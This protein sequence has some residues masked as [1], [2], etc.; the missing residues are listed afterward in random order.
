MRVVMSRANG[1]ADVF[2]DESKAGNFLLA[3]ATV[4]RGGLTKARRHV[5]TLRHRTGEVRTFDYTP[6]KKPQDTDR[7]R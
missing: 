6:A 1:G 4:A 2:V 7:D 3:A 5:K